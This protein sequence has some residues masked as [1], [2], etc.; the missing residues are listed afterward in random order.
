MLR[1]ENARPNQDE[2]VREVYTADEAECS[3]SRGR[4]V[5]DAHVHEVPSPLRALCMRILRKGSFPANDRSKAPDTSALQSSY[6][7][8]SCFAGTSLCADVL[9]T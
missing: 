2:Y 8:S 9:W 3:V 4:L 5:L 7:P 1:N 6:P